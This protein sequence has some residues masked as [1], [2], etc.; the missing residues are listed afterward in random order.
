MIVRRTLY[1]DS[2]SNH[3]VRLRDPVPVSLL[4]SLGF[5]RDALL[6]L[7]AKNS[8]PVTKDHVICREVRTR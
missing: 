4:V 3:S 2:H 1:L 5:P 8:I 7:P 6:V